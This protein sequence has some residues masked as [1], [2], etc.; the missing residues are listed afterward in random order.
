MKRRVA[1]GLYWLFYPNER[2]MPWSSR[3]WHLLC[4]RGPLG[5]FIVRNWT[6]R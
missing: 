6:V 4:W 5:A 3:A 1:D 2:V